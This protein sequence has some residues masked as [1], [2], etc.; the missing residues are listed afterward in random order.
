MQNQ[1]Q[2]HRADPC[3]KDD[4]QYL[5]EMTA[6]F[7]EGLAREPEDKRICTV[8]Q[9]MPSSG[10]TLRQRKV[11]KPLEAGGIAASAPFANEKILPIDDSESSDPKTVPNDTLRIFMCGMSNCFND[12][13]MA[14]WG[15]ISLIN[16]N[17]N[18]SKS[19]RKGIRKVEQLIYRSDQP[20]SRDP[21]RPPMV[22]ESS[23]GKLRYRQQ[24][25]I[26]APGKSRCR[27]QFV[28]DGLCDHGPPAAGQQLLA[29]V[30]GNNT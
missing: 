3:T 23:R 8:R 4:H 12:I 15:N 22:Q 25:H 1:E 19:V 6:L 30:A 10:R 7:I 17:A 27:S 18:T 20:A 24:E 29:T 13:L 21:M 14:I 9:N 5:P 26:Q 28:Y 2:S 16:M 11:P